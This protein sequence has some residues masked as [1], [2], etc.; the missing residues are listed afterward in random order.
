MTKTAAKIP[1]LM[2]VKSS[3]IAEVGYADGH[4]FVRFVAGSLYKYPGVTAEQYAKVRNAQSVGRV[5]QIEI[6]AKHT[7]ALVPEAD[8]A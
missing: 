8:G 5:L 1:A 7:G 6:L 4:L 3:S 2:R